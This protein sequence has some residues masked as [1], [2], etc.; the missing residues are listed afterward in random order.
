MTAATETPAFLTGLDSVCDRCQSKAYLA[1]LLP[2][3]HEPLR[4]CGHHGGPARPVLLAIEGV[5]VE[6][7]LAEVGR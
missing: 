5:R 6:D 7:R 3:H 4:F 2:G 1:V